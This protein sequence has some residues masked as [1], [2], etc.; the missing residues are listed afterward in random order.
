MLPNGEPVLGKEE[1][2][3]PSVIHEQEELPSVL[4]EQQNEPEP[5]SLDEIAD[6]RFDE[7]S[8]LDIP[9]EPS[10]KRLAASPARRGIKL[11][12]APL[13]ELDNTRAKKA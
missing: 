7:E 5:S 3:F 4:H 11:V 2:E 12:P 9:P 13:Q 10:P 8:D 6:D 1:D